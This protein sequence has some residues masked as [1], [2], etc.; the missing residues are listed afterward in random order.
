MCVS[1][2]TDIDDSTLDDVISSITHNFPNIGISMLTDT[3]MH[4]IYMFLEDEFGIL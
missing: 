2:F 1:R 3:Y 4:Q